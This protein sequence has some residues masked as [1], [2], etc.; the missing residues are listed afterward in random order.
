MNQFNR[1]KIILKNIFFE[2]SKSTLQAES[3]A[4][5]DRIA[6]ILKRHPNLKIE[7]SGHTDNQGSLKFN[8]ELSESRAKTVVDYMIKKGIPAARLT[9]KGYAFEIPIADNDTEEGRWQNRRVE[10]KILEN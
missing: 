3:F 5:L 7:I 4:E 9:Y 1:T 2:Y 8:T 10:V 6:N